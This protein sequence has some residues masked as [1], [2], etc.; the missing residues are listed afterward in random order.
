MSNADSNVALRYHESTSH[1][2]QSI[3]NNRHFLDW[4]NQPLPFK[5][6]KDVETVPLSR[7][8]EI[9]K[10]SPGSV[11]DT[12]GQTS[13]AGLEEK[14]PDLA[15]LSN[16][17][18]LTAGITKRKTVP[19]G[20]M[21]FR[22]YPNTGALY[23][24]DLYL[25]VQDLPDLTAGIYHFGPHD[26]SLHRLRSGDYREFVSQATGDYP[27]VKHAPVILI[28]TSTYWRNAW[29]YQARA[30]RHCYWD[31]GTLHANLLEI[32][33]VNE[34]QPEVVMGFADQAV[35]RLLDI[36]PDR[37]GALTMVPLGYTNQLP[38]DSPPVTRLDLETEPLSRSEVDYP[39]IREVHAASSLGDGDEADRWRANK[40]EPAR[41]TRDK[42]LAEIPLNSAEEL[43]NKSLADVICRRGSTRAF[44]SNRSISFE[45][46]STILDRATRDIPFDFMDSPTSSMV[47]LYLIVNAV[48][49]LKPG[50][51]FFRP[52]DRTL[53]LLQEGNF[54][55]TAGRLALGQ[56]L[57]ADAAASIYCMS[58]LETILS[59]FGDRG[60]RAAQL[61]GG[62]TGG[63]IY[64]AAY[65]QGLGASGSTFFD[66]E[67]TD[68]FAPHAAGKSVLF[69]T[70]VGYP[71]RKR[72]AGR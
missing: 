50:S 65:G 24:I 68:F 70:A 43:P 27:R 3:R 49:G 7:N 39:L 29:K 67:V 6:Y 4:D 66:D 34:L 47:D 23:H 8:P 20:E 64:L 58:S 72:I 35:E 10:Y 44:A 25:V 61:A 19:G 5:I 56:E 69:L 2:E 59:C 71:D 42:S 63:R 16:V 40:L 1:S 45:H 52:S 41:K 62:I 22:A 11:F 26:F 32:A 53:A 38:T 54:R 9:L 51:Y 55:Q 15:I 37:E 21:Y 60:Y 28:S 36:D 12:N 48:E 17:L 57:A 31:G 14:I 18:Y 46:L 13:A 30:Y 33:N